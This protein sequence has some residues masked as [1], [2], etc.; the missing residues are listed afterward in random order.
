MTVA[1]SSGVTATVVEQTGAICYRTAMDGE[2]EILLVSSRR[3]GRWGIPKGH[4]EPGETTW[5]AAQREAFEEGGVRGTVRQTP[6][7]CFTSLKDASDP[8]YLVHTHLLA[9]E[10]RLEDYPEQAGRRTTWWPLSVAIDEVDRPELRPILRS[11]MTLLQ[12]PYP[13]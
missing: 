11:A 10:R 7:G 1:P 12:E 13:A 6:V 5:E 8:T 4:I 3:N 9:V 2:L